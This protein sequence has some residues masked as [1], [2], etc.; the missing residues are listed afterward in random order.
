M[1]KRNKFSQAQN[2]GILMSLPKRFGMKVSAIEEAQN[3]N[4]MRL[5]DLIGSLQT[6][7]LSIND[8]AE[9]NNKSIAFVANTE[10][11]ME[12]FDLGSDEGI[13][14][15]IVF[16]GRQFNKRQKKVLSVTWS[17]E[18]SDSD[19]EDESAKHVNALTSIWTSD[20]GDSAYDDLA[21]SYRELC[22]RSAE[23][24]EEREKQKGLVRQLNEEKKEQ[25]RTI[26]ELEEEFNNIGK[27]RLN[28]EG[29]EQGKKI[30]YLKKHEKDSAVSWS[31]ERLKGE[32]RRKTIKQE[33]IMIE[34]CEYDE[35]SDTESYVRELIVCELAAGF[36]ETCLEN[37]KLL[38]RVIEHTNIVV[39]LQ[40]A[41]KKLLTIIEN[42]KR[43][44]VL[45]N[46]NQ[47]NTTQVSRRSSTSMKDENLLSE[48]VPEKTRNL[49]SRSQVRMKIKEVPQ[50]QKQKISK[51]MSQ[52]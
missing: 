27:S 32:N 39:I 36:S 35:E 21:A 29:Y 9:K 40:D 18:D 3:I 23:L 38:K 30:I 10:D 48:R 24:C 4:Q 2:I 26:S 19:I 8:R 31:G 20:D 49:D 37:E 17:E 34:A 11:G 22:L 16:F 12:E 5:D 42:L 33:D 15:A 7:E 41:K 45:L 46:S 52:H 50:R 44:G 47:H 6:F 1:P 14:N 51:S 25:L 28:H 43:D 13:S